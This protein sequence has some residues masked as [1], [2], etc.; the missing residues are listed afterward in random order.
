MGRVIKRVPLG[1]DW[2]LFKVWWGYLLDKVLCKVCNGSGKAPFPI[3]KG[4]LRENGTW[5]T[6]DSDQCP[7]CA[8]EGTVRPKIEVPQGPGYQLWSTI[9]EGSPVSPACATPQAL[10]R[11]I[12]QNEEY[13]AAGDMSYSYKEWLQFI[14]GTGGP[15]AANLIRKDHLARMK[16]SP[17]HKLESQ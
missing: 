3:T 5:F 4:Y 13:D 1:F 2:P 7:T 9:T 14:L 11:W 16:S 6:F 8:G 17:E 12:I 15:P 10:A